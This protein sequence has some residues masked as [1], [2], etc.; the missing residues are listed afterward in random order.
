MHP[1]APIA[2][3][4]PDQG[5]REYATT[6]GRRMCNLPAAT[7]RAFALS[8]VHRLGSRSPRPATALLP[9]PARARRADAR[10]ATW[11]MEDRMRSWTDTQRPSCMP[12][13][14]LRTVARHWPSGKAA[15]CQAA[16]YARPA[17]RPHAAVWFP[18]RRTQSQNLRPTVVRPRAIPGAELTT[19]TARAARSPG[20]V[21]A[22][23]GGRFRRRSAAGRA[24]PPLCGRSW[25]HPPPPRRKAAPATAAGG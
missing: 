22:A 18:P 25:R 1:R 21:A 23:Q 19:V 15:R 24:A 2:T 16:H 6:C 10:A 9:A 12:S 14:S 5:A 17:T 7:G 20:T 3:P 11:P 4:P 8:R 13:H